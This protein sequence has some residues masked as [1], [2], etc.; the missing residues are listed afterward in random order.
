MAMVS[1]RTNRERGTILATSE[2]LS[3]SHTQHLI[4]LAEQETP[5]IC[6]RSPMAMKQGDFE[7]TYIVV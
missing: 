3:K 4:D 2:Q 7:G 5:L 1:L 6:A